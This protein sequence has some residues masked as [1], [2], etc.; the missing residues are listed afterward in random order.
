[1]DKNLITGIEEIDNQHKEIFEFFEH[2]FETSKTNKG[3]SAIIKVA[4]NLGSLLQKHF[5]TEESYM[6]KYNY[7]EIEMHKKE[8]ANIISE[9]LKIKSNLLN[10]KYDLTYIAKV[11]VDSNYIIN[12]ANIYDVKLATF[13]RENV[14]GY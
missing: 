11:L 9:Y 4:E 1:M 10:G 2:M 12:H 8:H 7:P 3:L 6:E 5:E 14:K 13:F